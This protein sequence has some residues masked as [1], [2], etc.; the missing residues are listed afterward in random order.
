M[1]RD[2]ASRDAALLSFLMATV[3]LVVCTNSTHEHNSQWLVFSHSF[4]V[5][6]LLVLSYM[7]WKCEKMP[8]AVYIV[9]GLLLFL[10]GTVFG[11]YHDEHVADIVLMAISCILQCGLF[12]RAV[13]VHHG[14]YYERLLALEEHRL[15]HHSDAELP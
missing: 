5:F 12:A 11:E 14:E 2:H 13:Y 4:I 3:A 8:P 1:S 6:L 10:F 7:H 15:N 9:H